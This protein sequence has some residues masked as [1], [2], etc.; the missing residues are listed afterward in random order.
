ME[1]EKGNTSSTGSALTLCK[2]MYMF[3]CIYFVFFILFGEIPGSKMLLL[4]GILTETIKI[5]L[6]PDLND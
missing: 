1:E 4:E 3:N 2:I 6:I 5:F